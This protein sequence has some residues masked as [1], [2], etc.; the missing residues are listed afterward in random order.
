MKY[1]PWSQEGNNE[2]VYY[3]NLNN[4]KT[5]QKGYIVIRF[6]YNCIRFYRR[7]SNYS[8][9]YFPENEELFAIELSSPKTIGND[10]LLSLG[11]IRNNT[12]INTSTV[13]IFIEEFIVEIE[14]NEG[15]FAASVI[16]NKIRKKLQESII[17]KLIAA[18]Q[19]F[20]RTAESGFIDEIE[21]NKLIAEYSDLLIHPKITTILPPDCVG[22][23]KLLDNPEY[24]LQKILNRKN[25]SYSEDENKNKISKVDLTIYYMIFAYYAFIL[26]YSIYFKSIILGILTFFLLRYYLQKNYR[27]NLNEN[28]RK[29]IQDFFLHKHATICTYC[30]CEGKFIY[31]ITFPLM[32]IWS[33]LFVCSCIFFNDKQLEFFTDFWVTSAIFILT[34]FLSNALSNKNHNSFFPRI[35]IALIASWILIAFSDDFIASQLFIDDW[36]IWITP[37]FVSATIFVILYFESKEFSPYYSRRSLTACNWKILPIFSFSLFASLLIG[38]II[39]LVTFKNLIESSNVLPA[40]TFSKYFLQLEKEKENKQLLLFIDTV[41]TDRKKELQEQFKALNDFTSKYN[42]TDSLLKL[43]CKG[44]MLAFTCNEYRIYKQYFNDWEDKNCNEKIASIKIAGEDSYLFPRTLVFHSF[45]VLLISFIVQI[46]IS[47]KTVTEGLK[48]KTE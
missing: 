35:T 9:D 24:E 39:Q 38:V 40:V 22:V 36:L 16:A 43:I 3:Y 31:W 42:N 11:K 12:K 30:S 13:K 17:Y 27:I 33:V 7:N 5:K 29:K 18:K 2:C 10:I 45:I 15:I 6:S 14:N 1:F 41:N 21:Y 4:A 34:M 47:G 46:I 25:E 8:D 19:K 44:E 48:G 20:Y 32:L 28:I 26:K 37:F 23:D